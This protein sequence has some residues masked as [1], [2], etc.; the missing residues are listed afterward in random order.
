MPYRSRGV[1]VISDPKK[2]KK[3]MSARRV[4]HKQ[5]LKLFSKK[6]Y[7]NHLKSISIYPYNIL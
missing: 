5:F 4:T 6:L 1:M 7:T 3:E 2:K